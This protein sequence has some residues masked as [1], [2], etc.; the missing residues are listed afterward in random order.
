MCLFVCPTGATDTENSIIDEDKCI[1]CKACM[2]SCPSA[3]ISMIPK[4]YPLQQ[5][6][7]DEVVAA[8]QALAA[9]KV[10][11]E[12]V[13]R[14]ITGSTDNAITKQF[15][16]AIAHSNL[17]MAEDLYRESGYMLAQSEQAHELLETLRTS[18]DPDL[19]IEAVEKLLERLP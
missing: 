7:A 4:N 14:Q 3:A 2:Y 1:G 9:S 12:A 8:L 10:T 19:P 17:R 5:P 16:E 11:Q 15:A 13:A 18:A 6:K